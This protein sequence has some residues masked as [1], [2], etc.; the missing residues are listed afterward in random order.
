MIVDE[1][2]RTISIA[3]YQ[4]DPYINEHFHSEN[5]LVLKASSIT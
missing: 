3:I 5:V 1:N 2:K 4:I